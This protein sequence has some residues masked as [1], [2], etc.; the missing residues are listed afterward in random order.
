LRQLFQ[1]LIE[2]AIKYRSKSKPIILISAKPEGAEWV[3]AV[4]DN[5]IGIGKDYQEKIFGLFK[6]LHT[7]KEYAGTG[8]GLALCHNIV[9]F[10]GGRIWVNS[11][12]DHGSTFSFTLPRAS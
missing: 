8:L 6:R 2:N 3:F 1:N 4:E 10:Y 7:S 5:G 12:K 11:I 9:D